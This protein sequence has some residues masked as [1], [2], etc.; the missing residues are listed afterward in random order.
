MKF[1]KTVALFCIFLHS[2]FFSVSCSVNSMA[3]E[4]HGFVEK[5]DGSVYYFD[6]EGMPKSGWINQRGSR[7][8]LEKRELSVG[9]KLIED[10][11]DNT[12]RWYYFDSRGR[13]LRDRVT[14]DGFLV[15]RNGVYAGTAEAFGEGGVFTGAALTA[16]EKKEKDEED[17]KEL[18]AIEAIY[19][20]RRERSRE[21]HTNRVFHFLPTAAASE[22]GELCGQYAGGMPVEFYM[23]TIAGETSGGRNIVNNV[24]GDRGRAYGLCQMDYRYDLIPFMEF[25]SRKH[26]ELWGGFSAYLAFRR[27]DPELISHEGII[28]VFKHAMFQNYHQAVEDQLEFVRQCYW[29]DFSRR[30]NAAGFAL[31]SRNIAVSAAL[32]SINVN[33]GPQAE[34]F[35]S[36]LKPSLSDTELLEGIYRLRNTQLAEQRVG[37]VRKGTTARYLY[38]EP[39]MAMALYSAE[40]NVGSE[41][42]YG[43]G[44]E[45]HGSPF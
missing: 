15:D 33:C 36:Q 5:E 21:V 29:D 43:G 39:R 9:W 3:G 16:A 37:S 7:Y 11:K 17:R 1:K 42:V 38:A 10:Q 20:A 27:G 14:P 34:L 35:V 23:L 45:W 13:L 2:L 22:K 32:L 30:L 4:I 12:L 6:R 26:P 41:C 28:H 31:E 24:T 44:V 25:A 40:I 19:E 18:R 8:Y